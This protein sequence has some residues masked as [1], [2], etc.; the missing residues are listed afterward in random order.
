MA[1][2]CSVS[3]VEF[4][5]EHALGEVAFALG[6]GHF[7]GGELAADENEFR[8]A[9]DGLEGDVLDDLQ[10]TAVEGIGQAEEGG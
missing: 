4:E 5:V 1:R 3:E 6:G 9:V 10:V 7:A 8:A 2:G